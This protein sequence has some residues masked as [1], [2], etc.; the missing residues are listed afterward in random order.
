M[1]KQTGPFKHSGTIGG[2]N[3]YIRDGKGFL[4]AAGGGFTREAIK[5]SPKMD[6]VREN[7]SEFGHFSAAKK[8][9]KDSLHL[10]YG[11]Q[12]DSALHQE[13]MA[14]FLQL[15]QFDQTSE[16]GKR[17]CVAGLQNPEGKHFFKSL[18]FAKEP[19]ILRHAHYDA[20]SCTYTANLNPAQLPYRN[21][22]TH[23]ELYLGVVV[24]D[25]TTM[26]AT[27]FASAPLR[28]AK[29]DSTSNLQL[30]PPEAPTGNGIRIAVL[31][32]RYLKEVNGEFY[33]LKD[34]AVY[35]LRVLDV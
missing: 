28:I 32:H 10:F 20:E 27:L 25:F 33:L 35:G 6:R 3:Y 11:N 7:N 9:F 21:G 15:K 1:A 2:I 17:N 23:A 8:M 12:R 34:K 4:R 24:M 16:R 5:K 30:T 22:A 31:W 29:G 19:L 26:S 14:A 18:E 13:M